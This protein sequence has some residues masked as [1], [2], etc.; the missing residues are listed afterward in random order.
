MQLC[1][2]SSS[3]ALL[4]TLTDLIS[5]ER[6][7]TSGTIPWKG[8]MK[9]CIASS[10]SLSQLIFL[11][12]SPPQL[13]FDLQHRTWSR[14]NRLPRH[15]TSFACSYRIRSVIPR[16]QSCLDRADLEKHNNDQQWQR[17]QRGQD[18][19][20]RTHYVAHWHFMPGWAIIASPIRISH[21]LLLPQ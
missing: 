17:R 21:D 11:L 20:R 8:C 16:T 2:C 5:E 19:H 4:L 15:I 9:G 10:H 18:D 6:S 3:V 13:L 12:I 1:V 7:G 14:H